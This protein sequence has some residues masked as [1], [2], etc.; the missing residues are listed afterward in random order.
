MNNSKSRVIALL[1]VIPL[2]LIFVMTSVVETTQIIV[3]IPVSSLTIVNAEGEE[4]TEEVVIDLAKQDNSYQINTVIAPQNASIQSV[5]YAYSKDESEASAIVDEKTGKV[6]ALGLGSVTVN[7][8]AGDK[9]AKI[10]INYIM[11]AVSSVTKKP[12]IGTIELDMGKSLNLTDY[13]STNEIITEQT[14]ESNNDTIASV[15]DAGIV[16]GKSSGVAT[17]KGEIVGKK[18]DSKTGKVEKSNYEISFKVKVAC[19]V[20]E[21][22]GF[23]FTNVSPNPQNAYVKLVSPNADGGSAKAT[24]EFTVEEKSLANYGSLTSKY[25]EKY[26]D[27]VT[28]TK[29]VDGSFALDVELSENAEINTPYAVE[30]HSTKA[31]QTYGRRNTQT[32]T[33]SNDTRIITVYVQKGYLSYVELESTYKALEIG[34]DYKSLITQHSDIL[35]DYKD[36][37]NVTYTSSD[38]S[39][40]SINN[41]TGICKANKVGTVTITAQV[42]VLGNEIDI[43]SNSITIKVVNPLTTISFKENSA[44]LGLEKVKT[45]ADH[46]VVFNDE[47]Y[48]NKTQKYNYLFYTNNYNLL[49]QNYNIDLVATTKKNESVNTD[50]NIQW[51]SSDEDIATIKNGKITIKD[52]GIVTFTATYNYNAIGLKSDK[53]VES[54]I[55]LRCLK[56]SLWVDDYYDLMFAMDVAQKSTGGTSAGKPIVDAVVLRNDVML[57]PVLA[58]NSFKDYENYLYKYCTT[59]MATTM[60][61]TYYQDLDRESDAT[62]RYCVD[63]NKNI[64]GNGKY[65]CGEYI[66]NSGRKTGNPVF[67]GPL[68]LVNANYSE[69]E[70]ENNVLR[71]AAVKAQD[72]VVFMVNTPNVTICNVE[73]KGCA[74]E[75]LYGWDEKNEANLANFNNVG[76]VL[77]VV[78]DGCNIAYS[79]VKNGR[80]VVR[81]FGKAYNNAISPDKL[82]PTQQVEYIQNNLDDFRTTTT[83]SNCILSHGREFILKISSNQIIK[84]KNVKNFSYSEEQLKSIYDL[85]SPFLGGYTAQKTLTANGSTEYY[86][87]IGG[88]YTGQSDY[89]DKVSDFYNNYVLTDVILRDSAFSDSGLFCVGFESRFAGPM[90]F[91]DTAFVSGLFKADKYAKLFDGWDNVAGTSMPSRLKMEGNVCFYDWKVL[92]N[93]NAESLIELKNDFLGDQGKQFLSLDFKAMV[94]NY[95]DYMK[96]NDTS[97]VNLLDYTEGANH[98]NGSTVFYGGGKNYSYIDASEVNSDF[99]PLS[100]YRVSMSYFPTAL[101]VYPAGD[102][103]FR[104]YLY[105][106][107]S[108]LSRGQQE[109]LIRENKAYSWIYRTGK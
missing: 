26:I 44:N 34:N 90:L 42:T 75:T 89:A 10:K 53:Q 86:T 87:D 37:L 65:I 62:I 80:T 40:L 24:F 57:A 43:A 4:I 85:A 3:D 103:P 2:L 109:E 7:A 100:E 8:Y 39:I 71:Y 95:Q 108:T 77:E 88:M 60:D 64:Y 84:N 19:K 13:F 6:V 25:D 81:I 93:V 9:S 92:D 98:I 106:S 33:D 20:D 1:L 59:Q 94:T 51:T 78:E 45:I 47:F 23:A 29:N 15:D 22:T 102:E 32:Q 36:F 79:R 96:D 66:S 35:G 101:F 73:L 76:T 72:N 58:D 54:S 82:S 31:K 97:F 70:G 107:A 91:G 12:D 38:E 105:N 41:S 16:W 61:A 21:E 68:D 56:N 99:V 27:E 17:I 18:L 69:K 52:S 55:T 67:K 83:I 50:E 14:W 104:F 11:S 30:I 5:T 63:V 46:D 74:D 49:Q 28:I 48:N